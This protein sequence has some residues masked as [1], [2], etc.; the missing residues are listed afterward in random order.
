MIKL[1]AHVNGQPIYLNKALITA[2]YQT[3]DVNTAVSCGD[4][5]YVKE[6]PDQIMLLLK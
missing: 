2:V 1:T 4:T 6:T 3:S 5:W